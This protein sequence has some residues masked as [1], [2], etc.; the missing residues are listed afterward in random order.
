MH[1]NL[2]LFLRKINVSLFDIIFVNKKMQY[3]IIVDELQI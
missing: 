2:V 3:W 1:Y